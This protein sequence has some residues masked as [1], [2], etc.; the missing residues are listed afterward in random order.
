MP[1]VRATYCLPNRRRSQRARSGS[2][3]W[4]LSLFSGAVCR[5]SPHDSELAGL[6]RYPSESGLV[7]FTR[8]RLLNSVFHRTPSFRWSSEIS[9]ERL[10]CCDAKGV[11]KAPNVLEKSRLSGFRGVS[12]RIDRVAL[13]VASVIAL[14]L[15]RIEPIG[16]ERVGQGG[17][18]TRSPGVLHSCY[19]RPGKAST[20]QRSEGLGAVSPRERQSNQGLS[21]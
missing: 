9:V 14:P 12:P 6:G 11:L 20:N 1:S 4:A 16:I 8:R 7:M 17:A 2:C 5:A 21:H 10:P 15:P 3:G 18:S 19:T 13:A